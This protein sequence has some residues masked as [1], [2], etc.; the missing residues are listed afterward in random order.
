MIRPLRIRHRRI[1][2]MLGLLLPV[3]FG[4]GIAARKPVPQM[5]LGSFALNLSGAS[6]AHLLWERSDLFTNAP[7]L[8]R[9][10]HADGE[11]IMNCTATADFVKPDLL[12]YWSS[13]RTPISDSLPGD[14]VL[15][16]GFS[17]PNLRLPHDAVNRAGTLMLFSLA[18]NELVAVSKPFRCNA[19]T[20]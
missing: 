19:A 6:S 3:A 16:G 1:F 7:V 14:A 12:V 20:R 8:V 10:S 4:L 17:T 13:H 5:N 15:L 9:L 2:T 11:P 18:D